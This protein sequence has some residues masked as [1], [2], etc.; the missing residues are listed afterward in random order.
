MKKGL[1]LLIL[2]IPI[3]S[4]G[5]KK[6]VKPKKKKKSEL[7]K[8]NKR[9]EH[10]VMTSEK[11]VKILK[12]ERD[13]LY[14]LLK[15]QPAQP[16]K[17]TSTTTKPDPFS[18][19]ESGKVDC[20]KEV[21]KYK[22]EASY[23]KAF[24]ERKMPEEIKYTEDVSN[25]NAWFRNEI[26][27][28]LAASSNGQTAIS[29]KVISSFQTGFDVYVVDP[30][31]N[32]NKV[33]LYLK[34]KEGQSYRSLGKLNTSLKRNNKKLLFAMNGGM[35]KPDG[36]PQGLFIEN[37]KEKMKID[38]RKDE[39]G[40][41][42]MMPN[43]V[44]LIDTFGMPK[45]VRSTEFESYRNQ[46]KYATQSGPALVLNDTYNSHFNQWSTSR[47][48]RNGVGVTRDNKLVF[49]ISRGPVNL[50]D[51][52]TF[53]NKILDC[54][55]ALYLDGVVSKM[56]C[57]SIGRNRNEDIGGNFGPIIGILE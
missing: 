36:M 39:Y 1:I 2:I 37:G 32:S 13:S 5:Q 14:N 22:N 53:F 28:K 8:E 12:A 25:S 24:V 42:Y 17:P 16:A 10:N 4:F 40:N 15:K 50:Y 3:V 27:N 43:A 6:T 21:E 56:Y 19:T 7:L 31:K 9:L 57:P 33:V 30:S 48:V 46:T 41:F 55:N 45:V 23:W 44:F 20:S 26:I 54:P 35:Y 11:Q 38:L 29:S 34:N 18:N 51:F 47:K 52:A 49:V